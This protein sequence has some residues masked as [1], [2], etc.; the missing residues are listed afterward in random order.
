MV[1]YGVII[2][3]S[4]VY[5]QPIKDD[6]E[7]NSPKYK[8]IV[9]IEH[10]YDY[11]G[12]GSKN[13]Y[14]YT[15]GELIPLQR[16]DWQISAIVKMPY[17]WSGY[18]DLI[19]I[20]RDGESYQIEI[21]PDRSSIFK[22]C[23][24]SLD[25]QG[26]FETIIGLANYESVGHLKLEKEM[27]EYKEEIERWSDCSKEVLNDFGIRL[28]CIKSNYDSVKLSSNSNKSKMKALYS[29][30]NSMFD[31]LCEKCEDKQNDL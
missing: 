3:L 1:S 5:V 25:I 14:I 6:K 26:V 31:A 24:F 22:K 17:C 15:K 7:R 29:E 19:D 4:N 8:Y 28:E 21:R 11:N 10:D 13:M 20:E 18:S 23:G 27:L 9:D 12:N 2:M 16:G 30:I